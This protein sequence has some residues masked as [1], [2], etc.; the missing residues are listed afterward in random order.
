MRFA[1]VGA[2]IGFILGVFSAAFFVRHL[3]RETSKRLDKAN[4]DI[5]FEKLELDR[6]KETNWARDK[7]L[8]EAQKKVKELQAVVD[9][10][11][12][13]FARYKAEIKTLRVDLRDREMQL[14]NNKNKSKA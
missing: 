8:K 4:S 11:K 6:A 5:F 7:A 9:L 3:F 12:E 10:D 2:V 14:E 13:V 1:F